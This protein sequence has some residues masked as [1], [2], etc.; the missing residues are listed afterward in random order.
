MGLSLLAIEHTGVT[1]RPAVRHHA[2]PF[3]NRVRR[4]WLFREKDPQDQMT[5]FGLL[6][7]VLAVA[8][9]PHAPVRFI[10]SKFIK[11]ARSRAIA[12]DRWLAF[13]I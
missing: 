13:A 10:P 12:I 2:M 5:A 6:P 8:P 3:L 4:D 1:A 7:I 9:N 11:A